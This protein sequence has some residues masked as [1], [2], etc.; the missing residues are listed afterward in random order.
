MRHFLLL[1][2]FI[3]TACT[4]EISLKEHEMKD[5]LVIPEDAQ[6][7]PI[8]FRT[9]RYEIPTGTTVASY[10]CDS[11]LR[12]LIDASGFAKQMGSADAKRVFTETLTAQGYDVAGQPEF[13][14]DEIE[15]EMR[16]KYGI[17]ARIT[18]IKMNICP[19]DSRFIKFGA[20]KEKGAA[21]LT[22]IWTVFDYVNWKSVYKATTQG[23]SKTRFY[24]MEGTPLVLEEAFA[25]AAHNLGADHLFNDLLVNGVLPPVKPKTVYSESE[26]YAGKFSP[27]EKIVIHNSEISKTPTKGR[28][29]KILETAVRVQTGGGH[30]SG[31]FIT[32]Q[33]HIITNAHV[34]GYSDWA[35]ITTKGRKR[36]IQAEVLRVDRP[37]DVALLR[38]IEIPDK[39]AISTLPIRTEIPKIGDDLYA[40]GAP[41]AK[42][43][44]D[45]VTRGIMSKYFYKKMEKQYYIQSDV[46]IHQGNS[47]GP[48]LD[49]NGN[50]VGMSVAGYA[51]DDVGRGAGLNLFIPIEDAL[52]KLDIELEE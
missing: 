40:I 47:G 7:S 45:T 43:H 19:G 33:G 22:V 24:N 17:S 10:G 34:V 4:P 41:L 5:P 20:A 39:M 38:I 35:R 9:L 12:G 1:L 3:L 31:Y 13:V 16:V 28:F 42:G 27:D 50:I 29:D 25:M 11:F 51:I 30:G 8:S 49:E 26:H 18:D 14:F 52:D 44:Q 15:D 46:S 23:Y 36:K 32:P 48:L 6:P 37:R 2:C 21:E